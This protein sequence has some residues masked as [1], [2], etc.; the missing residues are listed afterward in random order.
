MNM[1]K[2]DE[3]VSMQHG[4]RSM[5]RHA[6]Q[7]LAIFAGAWLTAGAHSATPAPVLMKPAAVVEAPAPAPV[8]PTTTLV[9]V[10]DGRLLAPDIARIVNRGELIVAMLGVDSPPFFYTRNGE[11]V[12]LEVDLAKAIAKELKVTVRFDRSAQTFNE[13]VAVVA[14][15]EADLGVS[16]LSRT[17]ARAQTIS[18]TDPYLRLNHAFILN[19]VKFAELARDRPLPTVIRG[20]KGSIGVIA[21]SSFAD[22]AVKNFPNAE[23]REFPS[24]GDV[25]KALEKGQIM[26]AYRDEFEIKR[27]LKIDPT[28]SL[29][30]RTVTFKDLEDSLGIAVGIQ[31]P[32]LLAFVNQFLAEG[33]EKLTIDKVLKAVS[34]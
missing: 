24:W 17:L 32:T 6:V 21:K 11:L 22:Y 29:T 9:K 3:S 14:R 2:K 18:F 20:F 16:K 4:P 8:L 30:L 25:L 33:T 15:Q 19:R 5:T 1:T 26:A 13:V 12:G 10:A 23:I 28:V 27:L 31:D 7:C 34:Q